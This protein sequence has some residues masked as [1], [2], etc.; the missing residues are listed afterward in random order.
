MKESYLEQL[1]ELL[2]TYHIKQE[3]IDDILADYG[4]MIDDALNKNMSEEKILKMIGTPEEVVESLSE[5]FEKGEEY[6]YVHHGGKKSGHD[7]RITALMPFIS[8]VVFFILGF[9]F[10]LWHPGWLV[11]LSIP[12][13]AIIVNAFDRHSISGFVALSPFVALIIFLVLGFWVEMWNPA[14]LVFFV[15]PILAISSGFRTMRFIS[16]LTAIS[17]F[18]A[19]IV[20]VLIGTYTEIWNPTWLVFMII[21]MIGVLHETKLWK[22]LVFE[23]A[24]VAA[25]GVYLYAG[26][27]YGEWGLG[28][29]SFLIP[30][31]VSLILSED[32]FLVINRKNRD[33]WLVFLI[34]LAI[35]ITAGILFDAWPYL[36]MIFLLIPM[37][38]IFRHAP[39]ENQLLACMPFI[40]TILFFGTGYFL[41]WWAF[42]W[43]A[44][45][46]IPVVAIIKNAR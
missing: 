40:A 36:W 31:G 4:E 30:V 21:P 20:F 10:G 1:S 6:I 44:F 24:F 45:L 2:K 23:L 29:F 22:V 11:F 37:Y 46:L 3:E 41:G 34:L 43:M 13:V 18:V 25:I 35:Y 38:A 7:N 33:S 5:E 12:M 19:T 15:V 28:L 27:G 14:W 8:L 16:Y 39:R 17:P 42:S 32:S 26:Y 9:G